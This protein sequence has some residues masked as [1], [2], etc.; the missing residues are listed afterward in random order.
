MCYRRFH[1]I[2]RCSW[3]SDFLM[4]LGE[5][6]LGFECIIT[7]KTAFWNDLLMKTFSVGFLRTLI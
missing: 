2:T 1:S 4:V 7:G 6:L 5:C 3:S